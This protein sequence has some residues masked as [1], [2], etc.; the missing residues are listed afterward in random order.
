MGQ[1]LGNG[2]GFSTKNITITN[3]STTIC[4]IFASL[5][6]VL[7]I[8]SLDVV[9]TSDYVNFYRMFAGLGLHEPNYCFD[10]NGSKLTYF[11]VGY[12]NNR[13][14]SAEHFLLFLTFFP[15][16]FFPDLFPTTIL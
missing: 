16:N 2:I 10:Y 12:E 3:N 1:M 14:N 11:P 5:S 13:V 9:Y 7:P 8:S 6:S 4:I 15:T